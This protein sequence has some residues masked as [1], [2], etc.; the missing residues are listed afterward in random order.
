MPRMPDGRENLIYRITSAALK[1]IMIF[2]IVFVSL[3]LTFRTDFVKK[4][5]PLPREI[6]TLTKEDLAKRKGGGE[7]EKLTDFEKFNR[8]EYSKVILYQDFVTPKN[9]NREAVIKL[10]RKLKVIEPITDG[11]L[12]TEAGVDTPLRELTQFDSIYFYV[13]DGKNGGHILRSHSLPTEELDGG[14]TRLLF[15]L[16]EIYVDPTL[17]YEETPQNPKRVDL[18]SILQEPGD[19][20][21]GAFVS[22]LRYGE[23]IQFTIGYRGG[24]IRTDF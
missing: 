13:D 15:R 16:N 18:L 7:E 23:L 11:Y 12:Y 8:K 24:G 17:P 20:F 3:Y 4:Q 6:T 10:T 21:I 1:F 22:T 2:I 9:I 19:H 5:Q 14:I